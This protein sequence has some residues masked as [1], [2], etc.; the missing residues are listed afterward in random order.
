VVVRSTAEVQ[1]RGR[2]EVRKMRNRWRFATAAVAL[3]VAAVAGVSGCGDD[4]GRALV[5]TR[6]MPCGSDEV[7]VWVDY[8]NGKA[9]CVANTDHAAHAGHHE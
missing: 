8:E 1:N 7:Y 6:P 2:E 9:E 4:Q 5:V 3:G